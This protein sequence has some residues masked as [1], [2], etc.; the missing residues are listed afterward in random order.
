MRAF[1]WLAVALVASAGAEPRRLKLHRDELHHQARV[2]VRAKSLAAKY[3]GSQGIG[4]APDVPLVDYQDA[5]YYGEVAIGTPPQ[6]FQVIFDT[7]SSNLWVPAKNCSYIGWCLLKSKYHWES[8]STYKPNGTDFAIQYGSGALTGFT[9]QDTVT[10]A[11]LKAEKVTFAAAVKVP[12]VINNLRF[13]LGK[14]DGIMGMA[15]P[16][17]AVGHVNPVFQT[18][19]SQGK[20]EQALFQFY[21]TKGSADGGEMVLG[22]IDSSKFKGNLTWVPLSSKTYWAFKMQGISLGGKNLCQGGCTGIADTGTSLLAGP[23]A[24]V[25][26][27]NAL[28]G[29]MPIPGGEYVLI[30]CTDDTIDALPPVTFNIAGNDFVLTGKDYVLVVDAG[31]QKECISGFI[32]IDVP[33]GPLWI[34]GDLFIS[35]YVTVFDVGHSRVGFAPVQ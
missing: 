10:V 2:A 19:M 32:G 5:Q 3:G 14:F 24:A 8:S 22:G 9:C 21:L 15:F 18:L 17:I 28:I 34:L 11:G 29:A 35:Q 1:L 25:A 26:Q 7:G 16:S 33:A 20:V 30:N 23:T 13:A 12:G 27:L 4:E 31:K 6:S